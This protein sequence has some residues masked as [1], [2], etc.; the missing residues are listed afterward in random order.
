MP[1]KAAVLQGYAEVA[2]SGVD[3]T[4]RQRADSW[5]Y[6]PTLRKKQANPSL[7]AAGDTHNGVQ[8]L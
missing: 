2:S 7:A 3:A 5:A 8:I 4:K 6:L 1:Q